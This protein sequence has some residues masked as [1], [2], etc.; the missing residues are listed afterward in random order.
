M[1]NASIIKTAHADPQ[2]NVWCI[3]YEKCACCGLCSE[4]EF[5]EEADFSEID[6]CPRFINV[7]TCC[8]A[9]Q[10]GRCGHIMGDCISIIEDLEESCPETAIY[11]PYY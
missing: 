5:I 2:E 6:G 1:H 8:E 11:R 7:S 9:F 10:N 3:D 4:A